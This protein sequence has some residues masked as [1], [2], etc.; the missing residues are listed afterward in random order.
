MGVAAELTNAGR[1][2]RLFGRQGWRRSDLFLLHLHK[3]E[4]GIVEPV[5]RRRRR[6][7][8]TRR[9]DSQ[10]RVMERRDTDEQIPLFQVFGY[11]D[12]VCRFTAND[13]RLVDMQPA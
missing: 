9:T 6:R 12:T 2:G 11:R 3:L 4:T 1:G 13:F 5:L 7:P 10:V 8:E